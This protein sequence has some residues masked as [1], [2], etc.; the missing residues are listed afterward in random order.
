MASTALDL[1]TGALLN[2][3]SYSPGETLQN[4]DAQ[5]G[6]AVLNDLLD[7]LSTD[8]CFV[9]TQVETLFPWIAGQYQYSVGNP[10]GGTFLVFTTQSTAIIT[11]VTLPAN[12]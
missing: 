8:Q 7:S 12:I 6:L 3:N 2:I 11:T 4:S 1:I 9:Y 10:V 5:T